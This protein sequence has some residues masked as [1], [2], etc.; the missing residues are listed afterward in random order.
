MTKKFEELLWGRPAE[1]RAAFGSR[2]VKGEIVVVI[3]PR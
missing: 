2:R 1:I 3:G